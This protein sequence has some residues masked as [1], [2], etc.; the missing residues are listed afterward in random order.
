MWSECLT[1][2]TMASV[3]QARAAVI[4]AIILTV[5]PEGPLPRHHPKSSD[6]GRASG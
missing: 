3:M 4:S 5:K 2:G 6:N 1:V